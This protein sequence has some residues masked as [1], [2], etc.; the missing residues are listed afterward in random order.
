[1]LRACAERHA[2]ELLDHLIRPQRDHRRLIAAARG[3]SGEC[4]TYLSQALLKAPSAQDS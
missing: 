4:L 3:C 2:H 1:M